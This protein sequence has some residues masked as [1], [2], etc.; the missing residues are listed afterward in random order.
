LK[1][2]GVARTVFAISSGCVQRDEPPELGKSV[3]HRNQFQWRN[4]HRA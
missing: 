1:F 2:H 3:D 4:D